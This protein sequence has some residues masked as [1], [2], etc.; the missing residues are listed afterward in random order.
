LTDLDMKLKRQ[1]SA[2][3]NRLQ[4]LDRRFVDWKAMPAFSDA[5]IYYD[6][7]EGAI[8]L[9]RVSI[10]KTGAEIRD[11]LAE[12]RK[13]VTERQR[14]DEEAAPR[15]EREQQRK[16]NIDEKKR[17]QAKKDEQNRRR[18]NLADGPPLELLAN[19]PDRYVGHAW[20][21]EN[22]EVGGVDGRFSLDDKQFNLEITSV[23]RNYYG[24]SAVYGHVAVTISSRMAELIMLDL[25]NDERY[26]N[27][28]IYGEVEMVE[29]YGSKVIHIYI[30][31]IEVFNA[32]GKIGTVYDE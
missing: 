4:R 14:L 8:D 11:S 6:R 2:L 18:S 29:M 12:A 26:P 22:V 30:Y 17:K 27:C 5:E 10:S 7:I 20:K 3:Q 24:G 1:I 16:E 28:T 9:A 32:G 13:S 31:K 25:G 21:F 23:R 15:N 19:F